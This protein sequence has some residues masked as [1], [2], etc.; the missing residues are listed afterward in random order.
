MVAIHGSPRVIVAG[1]RLGEAILDQA[2]RLALESGVRVTPMWTADDHI[3]DIR[4]ES[5]RP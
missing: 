2:R 4:V 5:L 1:L 3:L